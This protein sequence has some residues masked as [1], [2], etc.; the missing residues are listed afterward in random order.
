MTDVAT[1]A[2]APAAG[3]GTSTPA[4][5]PE[6]PKVEPGLRPA[7]G[8]LLADAPVDAP[9]VE[10]DK[11]PDPAKTDEP[12]KEAEPPKALDPKDYKLELPEGLKAEDPLLSKFLEGAAEAGLP[13]DKVQALVARV[14]PDLM[15]QVAE[16][17]EAW[18][19]LQTDWQSQVKADPEIGG[20]RL[21]EALARISTL[22]DRFGDPGL[23]EALTMTGAGNN[24]AIIKSLNRMA[25][26]MTEGKLVAGN[27]AGPKR[28]IAEVMY[29]HSGAN[30]GP[31]GPVR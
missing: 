19:Q 8:N 13:Q 15:R 27:P 22:M 26:A 30:A 6:A 11:A 24:P 3:E 31:V 29:P 14:A 18:N 2:A 10:P 9:K 21:P 20:A 28:D 4:P 5:A 1:P 17:Y 16:P 12:K 25:L 7:P 23:R